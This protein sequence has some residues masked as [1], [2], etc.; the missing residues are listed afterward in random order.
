MSKTDIEAL[1]TAYGKV[2]RNTAIFWLIAFL[3]LIA[4]GYLTANYGGAL[5]A[6]GLCFLAAAVTQEI[7]MMIHPIGLVAI[8]YIDRRSD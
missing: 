6:L 3:A 2:Q 1:K 8:D 4:G 7:K 5:I